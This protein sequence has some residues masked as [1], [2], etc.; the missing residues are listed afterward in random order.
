MPKPSQQAKDARTPIRF[1]ALVRV[2]TER[3]EQRGESLAVQRKAIEQEVERLNGKVVTWYGGQESATPGK[4]K[5]LVGQLVT[6]AQKQ[7]RPFD[8]VIVAYTDRWSRDNEFSIHGLRVFMDNGVRFF[9][10]GREY[11]L[12]SPEDWFQLGISTVTGQ[13]QAST[14]NKRS[15]ESRISR[16]RSGQYAAG[17]LP[18]GRTYD[19]KTKTWGID[20]AKQRIIQDVARRYLA[21]PGESLEKI[22]KELGMN[23][24]SLHKTLMHRCGTTWTQEFHSKRLNIHA[25][26]PTT[27]PR[28][29][30]DETIEELHARAKANKTFTHG[31]PKHKYLLGSKI[32]CEDCGYALVPQMNHG[33]RR[34]YRHASA[35]RMRGPCPGKAA[36]M[37]AELIEGIVIRHLFEAFG[38]P[39]AVEA[40]VRAAFPDMDE[41]KQQ[42]ER[43]KELDVLIDKEVQGRKTILRLVAKGK[44]TEEEAEQQLGES[45]QQ[46]ETY[47]QEKDRLQAHLGNVPTP[48]T[49]K[50]VATD[51]VQ[52]FKRRRVPKG[53]VRENAR[54]GRFTRMTWDEQRALVLRIFDGET[55]DGKRMGVYVRWLDGKEKRAG[56]RFHYSING[57]LIDVGGVGP[58]KPEVLAGLT[59]PEP[60]DAVTQ[61]S[62][63][64]QGPSP[65]ARRSPRQRRLRVP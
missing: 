33:E 31:Q 38:N 64:R 58:L 1:A 4:E 61:Y 46:I 41:K 34:Y 14:S 7:P 29:L 26:V 30:S 54:S 44:T 40:A 59:E 57:L 55:P 11:N 8:A 15:L 3:Q 17:K 36:M 24:T 43:I 52:A 12:F 22:A 42:Q 49:L 19:K 39:A 21:E 18:W 25:T 62:K 47:Q 16:A 65:P 28:L 53:F 27:V 37:P 51:V 45:Q 5:K 60:S 35:Q 50:Q 63:Q 10:V 23:H 9:T 32:L 13:Y 6:D 20:K 56:R 2:S 48:E